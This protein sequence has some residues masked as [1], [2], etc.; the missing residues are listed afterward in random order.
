MFVSSL[1]SSAYLA[2]LNI[3]SR[4]DV[5]TTGHP[6]GWH[7]EE[8]RGGRVCCSPLPPIRGKG[9][10]LTNWSLQ[11]KLAIVIIP[12]Y[13]SQM[14]RT[15]VA[16]TEMETEMEMKE[17]SETETETLPSC[18]VTEMRY[19]GNTSHN[20]SIAQMWCYLLNWSS[21]INEFE[22]SSSLSNCQSPE[23]SNFWTLELSLELLNSETLE[24]SNPWTLKLSN[25]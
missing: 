15:Q 25:P 24:M 14:T 1:Y 20:C 10:K 18:S 9:S 6:G 17:E 2:P 8:G 3:P 16:E 7:R 4:H 21:D 5:P 12:L 19:N 23:L 22:S 13:R 11:H